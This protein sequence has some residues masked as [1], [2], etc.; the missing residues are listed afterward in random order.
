[1]TTY[2]VIEWAHSF[3][4]KEIIFSYM[5]WENGWRSGMHKTLSSKTKKAVEERY[6]KSSVAGLGYFWNLLVSIFLSKLA[7][8][9]VDFLGTLK[10]HY[11]RKK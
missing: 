8:I 1:M 11:V 3:G 9:N 6:V 5:E 10:C 2:V 7:Q 4:A